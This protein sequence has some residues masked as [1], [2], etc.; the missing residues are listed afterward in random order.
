[1]TDERDDPIDL[2]PPPYE[3]WGEAQPYPQWA[4]ARRHCPVIES[5]PTAW[6]PVPSFATTTFADGDRVLRDHETFSATINA[7]SIGQFMGELILGMDGEEHRRY[8]NLVAHAFRGDEPPR[9]RVQYLV[10]YCL[11]KRAPARPARPVG[12]VEH[13]G[14]EHVGLSAVSIGQH[15]PGVEDGPIVRGE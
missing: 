13:V 2:A 5:P 9:A 7:E 12:L 15:A 1:M 11:H 4:R 10:A 14:D 8:R 6:S 3:A